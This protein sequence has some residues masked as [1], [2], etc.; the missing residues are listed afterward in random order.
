MA[1]RPTVADRVQGALGDR[2]LARLPDRWIDPLRHAARRRRTRRALAD[3]RARGLEVEPTIDPSDEML[4]P[5]D[6]EHYFWVGRSGLEVIERG[7]TEAGVAPVEV[8]RILDVPCGHGRVLRMLRARW[9]EAE[10]VACDLDRRAVDFCAATFGATGV[11]SANPI[12]GVAAPDDHDLVWVGSL[13]T[14]LDAARWPELLHWLRDRLRHGGVLVVT[15][16]GAEGARRMTGGD[17]YGLAAE[18]HAALLRD[19]AATG[20]GYAP[21]PWDPDYGVSLSS[22]EW[23]R[24]TVGEVPGLELVALHETAWAEHHDVVVLR[25]AGGS[26]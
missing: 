26:A 25:R 22:A 15:T 18:A 17:T 24:R 20:F 10:I 9:P 3:L 4:V 14:H 11:Y 16:H 12:S 19:H 21:Y 23:V 8:R 1:G 6:P 7:L 13:L 2:V 5:R